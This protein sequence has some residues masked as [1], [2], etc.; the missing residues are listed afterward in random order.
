[1]NLQTLRRDTILF[2]PKEFGTIFALVDFG[3]VRYW[4]RS[5][6]PDD[7][8]ERLIREIDIEKVAHAIDLVGATE[9]FFYYGHY[10]ARRNLP[11]EHPLRVQYRNSIFR[12]DKAEKAGFKVLTKRIKHIETYDEAGRRKG[13]IQKCNFDVE[14][15]MDMIRQLPK[16]DTVFLWSGDSDFQPLLAYL[17]RKGK[18]IVTLCARDFASSEIRRVSTLFIPAERLRSQLELSPRKK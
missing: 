16:Y 6:W 14:I 18:K 5:F 10:R 12:I 8:R 3:N 7:N 11:P 17:K 9:K 13:E 2:N 15:T 1:M 4:A